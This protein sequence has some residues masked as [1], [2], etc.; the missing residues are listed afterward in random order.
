MRINAAVATAAFV[1]PGLG[2]CGF[3]GRRKEEERQVVGGLEVSAFFFELC[4]A[5]GVDER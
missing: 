4:F 2:P 3:L 1:Q 5:L